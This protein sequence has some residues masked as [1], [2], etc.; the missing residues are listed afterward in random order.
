[1]I[2]IEKIL[3]NN[4]VLTSNDKN[5]GIVV[6][7]KGIAFKVSKSAIDKIYTL[8]DK[9]TLS[10]FEQLLADIPMEYMSL[11]DDIINKAKVTLGKKLNDNIYISLTD[12]I[13]T[14]N[15]TI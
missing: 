4:V 9:D 11:S 10:K 12:H 5:E 3:N 14:G 15:N 1:M 8:S 13:H 2:I 6:M 7:G